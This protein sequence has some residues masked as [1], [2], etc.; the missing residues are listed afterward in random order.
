MFGGHFY[1]AILRK[2]VAVF[3]TLFNDIN[4]VRKDSTGN[5]L[6]I[7]KVPLSYGPRQKFLSRI[8]EQ[9]DLMDPKVAI[10]LPRMSFEITNLQYDAVAASSPFSKITTA[11]DSDSKT[12]IDGSVPYVIDMQLNILAKNQDEALQIMEQIIPTFRP[13]YSL[14]VN[15]VPNIPSIDVPITL[16]N[17][18]ILDD[19]MGDFTTRRVLMYTLDFQMKVRFYGAPSNSGIIKTVIANLN[20]STT[21]EFMEA[22]VTTT[23][24]LNATPTSNYDV[25]TNI[26]F[27]PATTVFEL[28]LANGSGDFNI[29]DVI[30]GTNSASSARVV[31]WDN[32]TNILTVEYPD[33]Y[34]H[35]AESITNGTALWTLNTYTAV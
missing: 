13:T 20:D 30:T 32:T 35:L 18:S 26:Q 12:V 11:S 8:D 2:S 25:V 6:D 34:F 9:A 31:A 23:D 29:G 14:S 16:Q 28:G 3:G 21:E 22:S 5:V 24:P 33:G 10:K 17:V 15:Y 1:H 27:I 19:Y 4:V 7:S